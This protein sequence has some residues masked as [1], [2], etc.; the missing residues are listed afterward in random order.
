[1]HSNSFANNENNNKCDSSNNGHR[2]EVVLNNPA[3]YFHEGDDVWYHWYTMF[4]NGFQTTP[5]FQVSTQWHQLSNTLT[6]GPAIEFNIDGKTKNL[7]MR[8]M[9]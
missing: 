3:N 9:P 6:G 5:R 7:D 1:M 8:V 4:P 2:A